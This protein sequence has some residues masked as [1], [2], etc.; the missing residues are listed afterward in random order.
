MTSVEEKWYHCCVI[1]KCFVCL[2]R[3]E[4]MSFQGAANI[5]IQTEAQRPKHSF[6]QPE[7]VAAVCNAFSSNKI[8]N[9]AAMAFK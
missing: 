4:H 2:L 1:N 9:D 8:A 6:S 7:W 3:I 5:V